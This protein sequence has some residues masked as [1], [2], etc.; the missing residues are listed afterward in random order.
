M[1]DR[2]NSGRAASGRQSRALVGRRP[3]LRQRAGRR[4]VR[5]ATSRDPRSHRRV[6]GDAGCTARDRQR[7][8]PARERNRRPVHRAIRHAASVDRRGAR[9]RR[10]ARDHRPGD[11]AGGLPARS[12]DVV[13][14][15]RARRLGDEHAGVVD[16]RSADGAR[17][18]SAPRPVEP[19]HRRRRSASR[20]RPRQ[21]TSRCRHTC[22]SPRR[23]CSPSW[24]SSAG[25]C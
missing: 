4:L 17:D 12:D 10:F 6:D 7:G 8:G 21:P 24:S 9:A 25:D 5:P 19:G 2:P 14:D 20:P 16:Q 23:S 18:E 13:V 11:D 3:V 22:S 15:G 1:S